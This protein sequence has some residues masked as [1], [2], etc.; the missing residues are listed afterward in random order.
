M[1]VSCC[2]CSSTAESTICN[3]W[4]PGSIPG[5]GYPLLFSQGAVRE[6]GGVGSIQRGDGSQP[7]PV[8]GLEGG[9]VPQR[10]LS[11]IRMPFASFSCQRLI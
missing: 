1:L 7:F 4:D 10:T 3:R 9:I 11:A 6:S 2:P 5:A 8:G